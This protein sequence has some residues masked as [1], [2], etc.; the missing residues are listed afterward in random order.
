M[1]SFKQKPFPR[2]AAYKD[3]FNRVISIYSGGKTF[4]C[5][6]WRIGWAVGPKYFID[7]LKEV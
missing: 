7:E 3:M 1:V 5:T 2:L 4:A 6:G